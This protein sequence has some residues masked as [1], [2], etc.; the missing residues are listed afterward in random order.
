MLVNAVVTKNH[1]WGGGEVESWWSGKKA[2]RLMENPSNRASFHVGHGSGPD[3]AQT[4]SSGPLGASM[5]LRE[6]NLGLRKE[7]EKKDSKSF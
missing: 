7:E 2:C 1:R 3:R 5:G 6:Q 4:P